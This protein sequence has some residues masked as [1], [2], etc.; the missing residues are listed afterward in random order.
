MHKELPHDAGESNVHPHQALTKRPP[1]LSPLCKRQKPFH[2][3]AVEPGTKRHRE[4]TLPRVANKH[5]RPTTARED[6]REVKAKLRH[7]VR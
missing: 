6:Q 7:A 5:T 4:R 2:S 1:E 3:R